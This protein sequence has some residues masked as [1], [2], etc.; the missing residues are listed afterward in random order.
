[1]NESIKV[2]LTGFRDSHVSTRR[3]PVCDLNYLWLLV[4]LLLEDADSQTVSVCGP[5]LPL[6]RRW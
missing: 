4:V 1:M 2:V 5:V 3:L 6:L